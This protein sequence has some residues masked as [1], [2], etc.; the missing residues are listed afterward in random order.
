MVESDC[1][2]IWEV[3]VGKVN[4]RVASLTLQLSFFLLLAP[5]GRAQVVIG[6]NATIG[7]A[8]TISSSG[9][10]SASWSDGARH[11]TLAVGQ[12]SKDA[13]GV[14]LFT[15]GGAAVLVEDIRGHMFIA[16]ALHVFE[17][18]LE[19]WA[20]ES[21]RIR[22][23]KDERTSRYKDFGT[24]LQLR[25]EGKPLYRAS[26]KFDLAVIPA[27]Q[28]VLQRV[29]TIN[30]DVAVAAPVTFGG[31][32]EIYDGANI[33]VLGFP[34]LVGDQYQQRALIRGGIIAWTDSDDPT[35][36]EF[37]I[38]SRIF[39]GNSG[40][41]VFASAAGITRNASISAGIP[42]KL[43]GIVSQTI[44][45]SPDIAFGVKLP[46]NAM[47]LGAAGVGIIEPAIHLTELMAQFP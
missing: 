21:L 20:P 47:I 38:D 45:A 46:K 16:T 24:V 42:T 5:F 15:T 44:N 9:V 3:E 39:P 25:K 31:T 33:F 19:H 32:E 18:P 14:D 37:L 29:A 34:A 4:T 8:A 41:P 30:N 2:A 22:G 26:L 10:G 27:P 43:L 23:W 7:G 11:I 40:G 1:G 13:S 6:G 28:D 36:N 17:N 35:G 12:V